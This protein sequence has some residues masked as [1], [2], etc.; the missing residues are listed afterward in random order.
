M[1]RKKE[2]KVLEH[3][4]SLII[5]AGRE[6]SIF[7]VKD[8]KQK[9]AAFFNDGKNEFIFDFSDTSWI[10]SFGI[11]FVAWMVKNSILTG[12]RV[13][14]LNPGKKIKDIFRETKLAEIVSFENISSEVLEK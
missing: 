8:L 3:N 13:I 9:I 11:A 12:S 7:E 2:V 5:K 1:D 10:D 14:I 4:S 6:F